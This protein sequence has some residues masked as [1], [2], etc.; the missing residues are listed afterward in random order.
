MLNQ[1]TQYTNELYTQTERKLHDKHQAHYDYYGELD[2]DGDDADC[3]TPIK[4]VDRMTLRKLKYTPA[5]HAIERLREYF[6]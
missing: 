5:S 6:G 3:Y 1:Y 4:G 2:R